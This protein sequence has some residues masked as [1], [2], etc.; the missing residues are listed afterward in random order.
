MLYFPPMRTLLL[1]TS[2]E[3]SCIALLG[4]GKTILHPIPGGPEL[5]KQIAWEVSHLLKTHSFSPEQIAVGEGPGSFTG[6]RVGMALAKA[7]SF[8][9]KIPLIGFCSLKIFSPE[10]DGYFT[11]LIDSRIAGIYGLNGEKRGEIVTYEE[12]PIL[13]PPALLETSFQSGRTLISP[14][15]LLI[16]KRLKRPC[17]EASLTIFLPHRKEK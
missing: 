9:W 7:L 11:V 4:G 12:Q 2:S 6:V 17:Q 13:M 15:P 3:K 16:E 14:H 10:E 1:E 5:S 8:G